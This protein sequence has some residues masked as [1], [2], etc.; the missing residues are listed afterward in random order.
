M[1]TLAPPCWG[2][3]LLDLSLL[4]DQANNRN[5]LG[6]QCGVVLGLSRSAPRRAASIFS[7]PC[8][9]DKFAHDHDCNEREKERGRGEEEEE[10]F[11]ENRTNVANLGL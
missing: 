2:I 1:L 7:G 9:L 11:I 5:T 6:N 4:V 10:E 3:W 8:K